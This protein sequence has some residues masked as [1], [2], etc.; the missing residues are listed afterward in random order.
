M[1]VKDGCILW[2][3]ADAD[4][5]HPAAF[6]ESCLSREALNHPV[7]VIDVLSD[8]HDLVWILLVSAS[9]RVLASLISI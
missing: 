5:A 3:R 6:A 2:L 4:V 1:L 9:P 8:A 7:L